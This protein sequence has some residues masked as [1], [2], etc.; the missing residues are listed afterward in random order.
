MLRSTVK[1]NV[2]DFSSLD[3]RLYIWKAIRAFWKF[4]NFYGDYCSLSP[5]DRRKFVKPKK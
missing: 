2:Q 5:S 1:L 3:A 4:S